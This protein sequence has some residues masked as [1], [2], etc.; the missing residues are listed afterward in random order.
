MAKP[1]LPSSLPLQVVVTRGLSAVRPMASDG[2]VEPPDWVTAESLPAQTW[3]PA[4]E[5]MD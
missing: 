3:S 4:V 2:F 5:S 1:Y